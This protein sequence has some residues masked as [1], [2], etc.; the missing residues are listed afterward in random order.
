MITFCW[1]MLPLV[2]ALSLYKGEALYMKRGAKKGAAV[3]DHENLM[4]ALRRNSWRYLLIGVQG[5]SIFIF[6]WTTLA[7]VLPLAVINSEE[8]LFL[9][10]FP[11]SSAIFICL[12]TNVPAFPV[13]YWTFNRVAWDKPATSAGVMPNVGV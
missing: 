13:A 5:A 6:I 3:A 7:F 1:A 10:I 4:Q 9:G 2:A 12:F 11:K 8:R